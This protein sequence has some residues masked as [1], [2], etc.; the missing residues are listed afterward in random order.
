MVWDDQ[1]LSGEEGSY[2][3]ISDRASSRRL[4]QK[5]PLTKI[6]ELLYKVFEDF[7][8]QAARFKRRNGRC[9]VFIIDNVNRLAAEN[10]KL[11]AGLQDHAKDATDSKKF[12]VVFV[13]SEGLATQ[14]MLDIETSVLQAA[15]SAFK[16]AR[17]LEPGEPRTKAFKIISG[18]LKNG[19]IHSKDFFY[20]AGTYEQ[21]TRL[22]SCNIFA[23]VP[24]SE[25]ITFQSK[26]IEIVA[27]KLLAEM[28]SWEWSGVPWLWKRAEQGNL[29]GC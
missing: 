3:W 4:I 13:T 17:F 8:D 6:P 20:I 5:C 22:L 12:I 9:A 19:K 29:H 23:T 27:R 7:Y 28:E 1:S 10:P 26:P 2:N 16:K 11:L 21:E 25:R 14:Q 15:N 18:I 24:E